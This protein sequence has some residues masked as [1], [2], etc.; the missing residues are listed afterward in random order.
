MHRRQALII[1]LPAIA[2]VAS[3]AS[4]AEFTGASAFEFTRKAVAFGPR[5]PNSEANAKQR[6]WI[7]ATAKSFGAQIE[8][9]RF[10]ASTPLGPMPMVNVI[11]KFPGTSRRIIAITGHCDTKM[12][13]GANFVGAN[14]GG[15][16][17]GLLLELARA[18]SGRPRKDD[19]WLVWFDGEEAIGQWSD[20]DGLHGSRHLAQKWSRDNTLGR[21]QA[22][23]NVDMIGD[24]NLGILRES[25]SNPKVRQIVWES[26]QSLGYGRYFLSVDAPIEDDH[27]PFVRLGVPAVDLID[28]DYGPGHSWWH[29][30]Q[31]TLD[32][33]SPNSLE[34]TGRTVMDAIRRL[35]AR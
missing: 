14:D 16:S 22:L 33:L 5:P 9:D 32:K 35:E 8:E 23:I 24:K 6:A 30:P 26:A 10:T 11:A 13:P 25:N 20:T 15:A 17:T 4:A 27:M 34:V 1:L 29:T 28:F 31:D 19:V 12:M 3:A 21:I 7:I 2:A 18:L